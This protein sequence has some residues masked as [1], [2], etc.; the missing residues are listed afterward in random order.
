MSIL[1]YVYLYLLT[2]PVFFAIDMLWLGVVAKGFYQE[3]LVNFLGPVNWTAAI[4]FYLIFIVG[5]LIFAV[6]PALQEQS[7]MKAVVLGAL[8]GFF[9]YAT[10]DLT[11]LATLKD[12]P[13]LIVFVDI[14]WGA[15]LSGSVATASYL[16]GKNLF[17]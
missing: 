14:L 2:V 12:W 17:F 10:Y 3:K 4:V 15:V 5:I 6:I 1:Q 8:F 13:I 7:L 16:I 11:N 9:T